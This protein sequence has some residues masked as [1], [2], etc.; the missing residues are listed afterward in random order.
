MQGPCCTWGRV[1]RDCRARDGPPG[2]P[3][4]AG[5]QGPLAAEAASAVTGSRERWRRGRPATPRHATCR[6]AVSFRCHRASPSPQALGRGP[7]SRAQQRGGGGGGGGGREGG[8]RKGGR[9]LPKQSLWDVTTRRVARV[10]RTAM[11]SSSSYIHT[12]IPARRAWRDLRSA[13]TQTHTRLWCHLVIALK[14]EEAGRQ[15]P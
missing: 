6:S 14:E 4:A 15:M 8:R 10:R 11:P 9:T 12:V 2:P 3:R 5:W 1:T 7:P 13:R